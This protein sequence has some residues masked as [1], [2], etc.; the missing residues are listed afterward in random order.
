[1]R[2]VHLA[3]PA[4]TLALVGAA[5][6]QEEVSHKKATLENASP[7]LTKALNRADVHNKRMLVLLVEEGEDLAGAWKKNRA[8]SRTLM[9]EF[10]IVQ[11]SGKEAD[12]WASMLDFE[13]AL[14][15]KPALVV[16]DANSTVL[17]RIPSA[18]LVTDGPANAE[19]FL[20]KLKPYLAE[21]VDADEK[22]AAA[23]VEAKESG[24]NVFIRFDAPW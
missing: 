23:L 14:Q 5:V 2:I 21:P 9:Y 12:A 11:F 24:R 3:V 1:M 16:L 22:L 6:G 19:A 20:A 18:A 7:A 4:L 17:A 13:A 15:K 10:E 8:I